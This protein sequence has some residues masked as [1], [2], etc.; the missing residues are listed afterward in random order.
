MIIERIYSDIDPLDSKITDPTVFHINFE[1]CMESLTTI[2]EK[3]E[4][5]AF[6]LVDKILTSG[7]LTVLKIYEDPEKTQLIGSLSTV[8]FLAYIKWMDYKK[9]EVRKRDIYIPPYLD[10]QKEVWRVLR[11][12]QNMRAVREGTEVLKKL[13]IEHHLGKNRNVNRRIQQKQYMPKDT[14]VLKDLR[15]HALEF[16]PKNSAELFSTYI[17]MIINQFPYA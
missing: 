5:S 1:Y 12:L 17:L 4:D 16:D 9:K 14:E 2:A 15:D 13:Q 7:P 3:D 8:D 6:A 10:I 11:Q